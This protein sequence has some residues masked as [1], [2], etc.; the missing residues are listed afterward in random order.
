MTAPFSETRQESITTE[1]ICGHVRP[2]EGAAAPEP[3]CAPGSKRAARTAV[4][5]VLA[6]R[7]GDGEGADIS[8]LQQRSAGC[9]VTRHPENGSSW[10]TDLNQQQGLPYRFA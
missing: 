2:R 5:A 4:P 7:S 1:A 6:Q 8:V 10:K 9:P 3:T